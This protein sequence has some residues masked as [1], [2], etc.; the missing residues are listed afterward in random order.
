MASDLTVVDRFIIVVKELNT[1]KFRG[2]KIYI[3]VRVVRVKIPSIL[4]FE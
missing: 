2:I 4:A 3:T 1:C